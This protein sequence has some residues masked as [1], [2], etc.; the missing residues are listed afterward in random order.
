MTEFGKD[1]FLQK[2]RIGSLFQHL[3]VV[4]AFDDDHIG[5]DQIADD[6]F[7]H[8]TAVRDQGD[9]PSLTSEGITAGPYIV[10]GNRE[11]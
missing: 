1:A 9:F 11:G 3:H 8:L 10:V 6:V 2:I 7:A 4:I 5:S